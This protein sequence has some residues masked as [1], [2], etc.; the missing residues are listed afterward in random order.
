MTFLRSSCPR[1]ARFNNRQPQLQRQSPLP[2]RY[3]SAQA[4]SEVMVVVEQIFWR[5]MASARLNVIPILSTGVARN[6]AF[7]GRHKNIAFV[8]AASTI[9]RF[10][11]VEMVKYA[12]IADVVLNFLLRMEADQNAMGTVPT[13]AVPSLD[14]AALEPTTVT[15]LVVPTTE[16]LRPYPS[17]W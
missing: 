9:A 4:I 14:T 15:A 16:Q 13:T 5:T 11:W 17:P 10:Y 8:I 3:S 6:L 2:H 1:E 12:R 7:A